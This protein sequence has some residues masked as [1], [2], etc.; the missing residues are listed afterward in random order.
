M[1]KSGEVG[2]F[3]KCQLWM[4]GA[5]GLALAGRL[6]GFPT[7]P[8]TTIFNCVAGLPVIFFVV[9]YTCL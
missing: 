5:A 7:S 2:L 3:L 1:Q 6:F 4:L 9:C 8:D